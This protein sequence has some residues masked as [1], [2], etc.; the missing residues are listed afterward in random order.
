LSDESQNFF[1]VLDEVSIMVWTN[2]E[3]YTA[4]SYPYERYGGEMCTCTRCQDHTLI[5]NC[6]VCGEKL[7]SG[8]QGCPSCKWAREI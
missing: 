1:T 3:H 7:P 6:P 5:K 2:N 4:K 8:M